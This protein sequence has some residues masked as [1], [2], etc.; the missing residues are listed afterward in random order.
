MSIFV[1][2]DL[3]LSQSTDKP[4]DIFGDGWSNHTKRLMD[5]W[6]KVVKDNDYVII[7]GDIS[8]AMTEEEVTPDLHLVN[9]LPGKKIILKGNHELWWQSAHKLDVLK[10][11]KN[12][13]TLT[14]LHNK[15]IYLKEYDVSICGTRGWRCPGDYGE[16]P[17][18][19]M[20]VYKRELIRLETSLRMGAEFGGEL[21]TFMHFPPFNA[22]KEPSGFTELLE[23]YKVE[24]CYYGHLHGPSHAIALN[25]KLPSGGLTQYKLIASDYLKFEPLMIL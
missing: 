15:A 19:D 23:K 4:M 20:K 3:H 13:D 1:I 2:A 21:L 7:P 11:N 12:F 16:F 18:E 5:N 10:K 22:H 17:E 9:I 14:F 25:G 6:G 24:R 8:W